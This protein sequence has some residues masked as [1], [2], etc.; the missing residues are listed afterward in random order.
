MALERI[1]ALR[2]MAPERIDS[3]DR[4]YTLCYTDGSAKDGVHDGGYGIL[5][6]WPDGTTTR[7]SG[8][9]GKIT[10]SYDCEYKAFVE[11]LRLVLRRHREG[12]TLT[13]VVVLTD[14]QSLVR[15]LRGTGSAEVGEALQLVEELMRVE[16]VRVIVQWLPSHVGT[17]GQSRQTPTAAK[18]PGH[19]NA[20]GTT[21]ATQNSCPLGSR[22][23]II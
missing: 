9:V 11:C 21:S 16:N 3:F 13:G 1:A 12:T 7:A 19:P 8:P 4:S 6:Q 14:C 17:G 18:Q 5:V 20:G 10:C 2:A 23:G 22:I 15:K